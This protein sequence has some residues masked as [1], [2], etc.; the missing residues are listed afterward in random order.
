MTFTQYDPLGI[1]EQNP[2][3]GGVCEIKQ[4]YLETAPG[5]NNVSLLAG[6]SGRKFRCIALRIASISPVATTITIKNAGSGLPMS[7]F[8]PVPANNAV[9]ANGFV[10]LPPNPLGHFESDLADTIY[11]DTGAG[12]GASIYFRYIEIVV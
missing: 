1:F 6:I 10:D 12:A 8:F 11:I 7:N 2:S 5:T 3:K 9:V 4:K